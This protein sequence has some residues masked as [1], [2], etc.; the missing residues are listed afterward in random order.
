MRREGGLLFCLNA[1]LR[2]YNVHILQ[3]VMI[4]MY[5]AHV[6]Y[7]SSEVN[8]H[9]GSPL[10]ALDAWAATPK[11]ASCGS[12]WRGTRISSPGDSVTGGPGPHYGNKITSPAVF[13]WPPAGLACMVFCVY[14]HDVSGSGFR[15]KPASALTLRE[16]SSLPTSFPLRCSHPQTWPA[17]AGTVLL[18][19]C[20]P[21]KYVILLPHPHILPVPQGLVHTHSPEAFHPQL[22]L[23]PVPHY[24]PPL[25]SRILVPSL[26]CVSAY[27]PF[28]V[29]PGLGQALHPS[30]PHPVLLRS[31][32]TRP[33]EA[34]L[35]DEETEP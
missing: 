23:F 16:A 24:L 19:P 25:K 20:S 17:W 6:E 18:I 15:M 34:C 29:G 4:I 31:C 10:D 30:H 28:M 32:E 27:R 5:Y 21:V 8:S 13:H 26:T 12:R 35:T 2:S 22:S 11:D 3:C 7:P 33:L 1:Y 9:Q 14:L